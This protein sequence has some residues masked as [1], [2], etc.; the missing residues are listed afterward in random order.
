MSNVEGKISQPV[1]VKEFS[2]ATNNRRKVEKNSAQANN[3]FTNANNQSV[4]QT[5][6]KDD[7]TKAESGRIDAKFQRHQEPT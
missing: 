4:N 6:S 5:K 7:G 2:T 3:L 1:Y